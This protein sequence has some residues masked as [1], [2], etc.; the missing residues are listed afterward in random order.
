MIIEKNKSLNGSLMSCLMKLK[1]V[2]F[3]M[4]VSLSNQ[5]SEIIIDKVK[6]THN[7]L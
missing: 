4:K 5:I 6:G 1:N 3:F 7:I 2:S